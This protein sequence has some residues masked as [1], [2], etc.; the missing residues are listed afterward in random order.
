MPTYADFAADR[1]RA[2]RRAQ[3]DRLMAERH[4]AFD[5]SAQDRHM[6]Y[7]RPQFVVVTASEAY[8]EGYEAIRWDA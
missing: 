7:E 1:D 6:K 8:R 4:R 2:A 3:Q 5:L